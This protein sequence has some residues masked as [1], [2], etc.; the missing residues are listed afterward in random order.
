MIIPIYYKGGQ[1]LNQELSALIYMSGPAARWY[2]C[3]LQELAGIRK[4]VDFAV[5][6]DSLYPVYEYPFVVADRYPVLHPALPFV[7]L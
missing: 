3:R 4:S 5:Q 6:E 1:F 7:S 2:L